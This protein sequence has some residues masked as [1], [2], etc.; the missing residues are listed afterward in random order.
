MVR[1]S[2]ITGLALLIFACL[3]II[4]AIRTL[5]GMERKELYPLLRVRLP[6]GSCVPVTT[7]H[8]SSECWGIVKRPVAMRQRRNRCGVHLTRGDSRW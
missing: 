8:T 7:M 6:D 2:F 4:Y 3:P 1:V 5:I